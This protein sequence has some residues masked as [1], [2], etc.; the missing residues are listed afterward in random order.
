M[1]LL[2]LVSLCLALA[3]GG[4]GD[5]NS[6]GGNSQGG[7]SPTSSPSPQ[8]LSCGTLGTFGSCQDVTNCASF[9]DCNQTSKKCYCLPTF[10]GNASPANH[11][12]CLP[13]KKVYFPSFNLGGGAFN[14]LTGDWIPGNWGLGNPICIDL[15]NLLAGQAAQVKQQKHIQSVL[16]FLGYTIYPAPQEILMTKGIP[17]LS[18]ILNP[19]V[20]S[21]ISPAGAFDGFEGVVEYFYGFVAT[22]GTF[23][24]NITVVSIAATNNTVG[25]K[26][27]LF[28][29]NDAFQQTGGHPP[30]WWNLSLFTFFTFDNNDLISSIDVS[31]P[32]LGILLDIPDVATQQSV[33]IGT[34]AV[35]TLPTPLSNNASQ[36]TCG[37]KGIYPSPLPINT[38]NATANVLN[39]FQ[40]CVIFMNSIPYGSRNRMNMNNFVCRNLHMLLTPY[41]PDLHCPH[42]SPAGGG[43]GGCIDHTYESFFQVNY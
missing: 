19:N 10:D 25:C 38:A 27:T 11:C 26:A 28:L 18:A 39:Q 8:P 20:K 16:T 1:S 43:D 15:D 36:G 37:N 22:P 12:D 5:G 3:Y 9:V 30:Q 21:R 14:L 4:G 17:K 41:G 24:V 32:N 6:Q 23:V 35:L 13:P 33:I 29:R 34:C 42:C 40:N 31:V 7:N 2:F